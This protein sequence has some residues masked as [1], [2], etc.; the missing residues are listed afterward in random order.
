M[1]TGK[2]QESS[3]SQR[4][5]SFCSEKHQEKRR[6]NNEQVKRSRIKKKAELSKLQSSLRDI[7]TRIER[8]QRAELELTQEL[9][10][11]NGSLSFPARYR[12]SLYKTSDAVRPKWFGQPF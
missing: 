3:T 4:D 12:P 2:T 8:L 6:R 9:E 10:S 11:V 1:G 5:L 7:E